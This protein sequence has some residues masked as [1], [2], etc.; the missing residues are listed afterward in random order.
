MKKRRKITLIRKDV[1]LNPAGA[2]IINFVC[3]RSTW[4]DDHKVRAKCERGK[5][6]IAKLQ[7]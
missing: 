3:V 1:Y 5:R 2:K 4:N 6:E 7:T